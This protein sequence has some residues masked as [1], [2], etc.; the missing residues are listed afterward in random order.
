MSTQQNPSEVQGK[1]GR[2]R[3][4]E[5]INE[6]KFSYEAGAWGLATEAGVAGTCLATNETDNLRNEQSIGDTP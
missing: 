4:G 1:L 2:A 5:S 6:A 3:C